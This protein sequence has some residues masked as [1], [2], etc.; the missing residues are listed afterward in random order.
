MKYVEITA[1][2][3]YF[4]KDNEKFLHE[5]KLKCDN[6]NVVKWLTSNYR[7]WL[8]NKAELLP[9][10]QLPNDAPKWL[11]DKYKKEPIF[12]IPLH[13]LNKLSH[14]IDYLNTRT[15]N[16]SN[17]SVTEVFKQVE[18]WDKK[19]KKQKES[20]DGKTKVIHEYSDGYKWVQLLDERSLKYE[21]S[22]MNHCVGGYWNAVKSGKTVIYS[23]RDAKNIP[24]VTVEYE[25]KK[26]IIQQ[27]RGKGNTK[28]TLKYD[29]MFLH[30][31]NTYFKLN[32]SSVED[33]GYTFITRN[34]K[35]EICSM[36]NIPE[37]STIDTINFS[38]WDDDDND[39]E[40][41]DRELIL[42]DNLTVLRNLILENINIA[43]LPNKLVVN[44]NLKIKFCKI[45]EI[46]KDLIVRGLLKIICSPSNNIVI[47][48]NYATYNTADLYNVIISENV[49]I[50]GDLIITNKKVESIPDNL[51]VN[52]C[53]D[54]NTRI[55]RIGKNV[56]ITKV[57][58][59]SELEVDVLPS[60]FKVGTLSIY[61]GSIKTI[62][63][64]F[65]KNANLDFQSINIKQLP[66]NLTCKRLNVSDT[67]ITTLPKLS[68]NILS[69]NNTKIPEIS[70]ETKFRELLCSNSKLS[71]LPDGIKCAGITLK[72]L[73]MKTLPKELEVS[74]LYIESCK[75]TQIPQD[76]KVKSL[77]V[78]EGA[79]KFPNTFKTHT[80]NLEDLT[81]LKL[82]NNLS[83]KLVTISNCKISKAPD[84]LV[85][86][87]SVIIR[88]STLNS[89]PNDLSLTTLE[90]EKVTLKKLP[91]NLK[92]KNIVLINVPIT[93]IPNDMEADLLYLTKLTKPLTIPKD[94]KIKL[95]RVRNEDYM[96]LITNL[97][98]VKIEIV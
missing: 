63:P 59:F 66:D 64:K 38:E 61:R 51:T 53:A 88:Y 75:I 29:K 31:A 14:I 93:E 20:T 32:K 34:G 72:N 84:I 24:H 55:K 71:K 83:A 23:L 41:D 77:Q 74:E 11:Q 86:C 40:N 85:D 96:S 28:L 87:K 22:K 54:F 52:G 13:Y 65:G 57:C 15:D 35:P 16:V 6:S 95:I 80:L 43:K 21:G 97:S 36:Y 17:M 33:S 48:P 45:T 5:M 70:N 26:N 30:F 73:P 68:T 44:G 8:T 62:E 46:P 90:L 10:S 18:D 4:S 42:P 37:N 47:P 56:T 81:D 25:P 60:T 19:L 12:T 91:S 78:Y 76:L 92:A 67:P 3:V 2:N 7:N 58:E 82:P 27:V 39:N 94:V 50:N 9:L 89:L 79:I 49:T 1:R 98:S 69:I